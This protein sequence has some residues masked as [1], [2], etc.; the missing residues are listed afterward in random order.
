MSKKKIYTYG[1]EKLEVWQRAMELTTRIYKVSNRFPSKEQFGLIS[2]LQRSAM[3][4]G[5]NIAEGSA[6]KSKN[7]RARFYQIAFSSLMETL[8]HLILA[9]QL[10]Y[11]QENDYLEL[12]IQIDEVARLLNGL[13][14]SQRSEAGEPSTTYNSEFIE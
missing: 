4:I 7:D 10:T 5:A 14:R 3:S 6:R 12:R 9:T 1:F 13:Y 11:L 2:Q 8:N